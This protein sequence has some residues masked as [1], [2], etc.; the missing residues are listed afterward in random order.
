MFGG[1]LDF[2]GHFGCLLIIS[3]CITGSGS[4]RH[5]LKYLCS[6]FH[7]FNIKPTVG[8]AFSRKNPVYAVIKHKQLIKPYHIIH[9]I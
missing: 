3:R 1:H 4:I 8:A 6:N 7:I 5:P 9:I 2:G